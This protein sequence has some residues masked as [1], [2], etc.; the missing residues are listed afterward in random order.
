M[1]PRLWRSF[2]PLLFAVAVLLTAIGV[3]MVYA[4]LAGPGQDVAARDGAIREAVF[5][6]LGLTLLI[7]T[8]FV[9]YHIFRGLFWPLVA[10]NCLFLLAVLVLG[11]ASYGAQRWLRIG[12]LPIQPSE[13]GKLLVILTLARVLAD[14]DDQI[15]KFTTILRSLPIALLPAALVFPQPDLG[16]A[17]V[18][19]A[20]W[21]GMIIGAGARWRHLGMLVLV[22]LA[23]MPFLFHFLHSYQIQRL[24]IFLRPESDPTGAGYNIIQALIAIGSGGLLGQGWTFGTQTQFHFLRVQQSDFIFSVIAEQLGFLGSFLILMLFGLLFNRIVR[25]AAV[26]QDLYGRLVAIGVFWML[27]F[28]TFVNMGMNL[29]LMPVTGIPLPLISAGGSSLV[30]SLIAIGIV[31]SIHMRREGASF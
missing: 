16:T 2:D 14:A 26:S 25:A 21:V 8:C 18:Y 29:Q 27:L 13:L 12:V 7:G 5:G 6:M 19:G 1:S 15:T 23:L 10:F 4:A 20:I 28:Q 22:S 24:T 31:E 11:H 9:D 3:T 30:T 17:L